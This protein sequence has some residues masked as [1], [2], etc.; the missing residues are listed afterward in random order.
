MELQKIQLQCFV[1]LD[2]FQ[3]ESYFYVRHFLK[4]PTNKMCAVSDLVN[5]E[6]ATVCTDLFDV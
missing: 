3:C 6:A 4:C 1:I 5:M 2:Y